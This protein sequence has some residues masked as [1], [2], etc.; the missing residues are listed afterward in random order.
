MNETT[1]RHKRTPHEPRHARRRSLLAV[2]AA[3]AILFVINGLVRQ[4]TVEA[5][6]DVFPASPSLPFV[7]M[8]KPSAWRCP[9]PLPVG[10]GKRSSEISVVN[11]GTST[12][13]V[14]VAVSR[15]GTATGG[16]VG[17]VSISTSKFEVRG[18]SQVVM[19][20]ARSGPAG[21]AA[22]S[23][24]TDSGGIGVAESIRGASTLAGPVLLSSPCAVGAA[25]QGYLA[26]GSTYLRSNVTLALYNPDATPA[27]VNVSV[28][29]GSA[30]TYPSAFQGLV[31]PASG[32]AVLDLPRWVPQQK[33][34]AVTATAVSGVVVVGALETNSASV[35]VASI[36]KGKR[37]ITN[38]PVTGTSLLVGPEDAFGSWQFPAEFTNRGPA[39][40]QVS[41]T[42]SV[43]DPGTR[44]T[45]VTV[46]PP[47]RSGV[48][49][50]L[51]AVVPAGGVVDFATPVGA[52][53][54][55]PG[56]VSV[57]AG[58][59]V[60]IVVVRVST[61]TGDPAVVELSATSGTSGPREEW[62][63]SG[64]VQTSK[65]SDTLMFA[66]PGSERSTVTLLG[67]RRGASTVVH[68]GSVTVRAG[69][70]VTFELA[71]VLAHAPRLAVQVSATGP[72]LAEQLF[73]P[74]HGVTTAVGGIPVGS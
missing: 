60:P 44:S 65:V 48:S 20:L 22:V 46:A 50:A 29:T 7:N 61:R 37:R 1:A 23:V 70:A 55:A 36:V 51:S 26:T 39:E 15:T 62:L 69:S 43:Y 40:K 14:M 56:A 3:L 68:L 64:A 6:G 12:V 72:I 34:V 24:E 16:A 59:G 47:G 17:A 45:L 4:T 2:V 19:P 58:G 57:S 53:G 66:N 63:I 30:L 10:K 49:A 32:L 21:F 13:G 71:S 28:S 18:E 74:T 8:A 54:F 33:T 73:T 42:F 67:L 5:S 35:A 27:V 9:G 31:V 52:R 41:S 11:G 25:A 38:L